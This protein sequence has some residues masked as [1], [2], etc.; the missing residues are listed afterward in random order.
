MVRS[1]EK[2][3]TGWKKVFTLEEGVASLEEVSLLRQS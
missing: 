3:H 2:L 1:E